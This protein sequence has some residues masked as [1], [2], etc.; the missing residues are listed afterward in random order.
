[1]P[2]HT[3]WP[4]ARTDSKS[5]L[6]WGNNNRVSFRNIVLFVWHSK[7]AVAFLLSATAATSGV[8]YVEG[9]S[10]SVGLVYCVAPLQAVAS[11]LWPFG[12]RVIEYIVALL[13]ATSQWRGKLISCRRVCSPCQRSGLERGWYDKGSTADPPRQIQCVEVGYYSKQKDRCLIL[14]SFARIARESI[15]SL[16]ILRSS[17]HLALAF[18]FSVDQWLT[19]PQ[20]VINCG[21][22]LLINI[23]FT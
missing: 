19:L 5:Q 10:L 9:Q 12:V 15:G 1:M 7:V 21:R 8:D 2:T 16:Y 23:V 11:L 4:V 20:L 18:S 14:F 17:P 22:E 6:P 3:L 13:T